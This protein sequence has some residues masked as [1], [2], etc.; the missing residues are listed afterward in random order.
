MPTL[1]QRLLRRP[2]MTIGKNSQTSRRPRL[3]RA[4]KDQLPAFRITPADIALLQSLYDFRALDTDQL[5]R[6]HQYK[7]YSGPNGTIRLSPYLQA[8]LRGLYHHGYA[9]REARATRPSDKPL[10]LVYFLDRKGALLLAEH[11]G[12]ELTDLHWTPKDR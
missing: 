7:T 6:L 12:Q 11:S 10:P 2:T 5:S 8:R 1:F 9:A 4:V 3:Q